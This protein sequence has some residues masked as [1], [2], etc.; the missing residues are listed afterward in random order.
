MPLGEVMVGSEGG[1]K[2]QVALVVLTLRQ[3]ANDQLKSWS[4]ILS[5]G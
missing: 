4:N 5:A 3:L 2:R 1:E